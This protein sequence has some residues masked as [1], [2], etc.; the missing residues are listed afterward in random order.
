MQQPTPISTH[1]R[2]ATI[3]I[4]RGFALLGIFLVNIPALSAPALIYDLYSIQPAYE[5][6]DRWVRLIYDLFVQAK[7]YPMFSFLFGFGFYIFLSRAEL[8]TDQPRKLFIRRLVILLT[9]GLLHLVFVWYGDILHTYA[10]IGFLLLF[11]YPL[12]PKT[13]LIWAAS[14]LFLFYALLALPL[15]APPSHYDSLNYIGE[16]VGNNKVEESVR[17]YREAGYFELT[18]YRFQ[19][20]VLPVLEY[21]LFNIPQILAL[22]LLGLYVGKKGII[23]EPG[24][25]R[26]LIR[27]IWGISIII[28]FPLMIWLTSIELGWLDYGVHEESFSYLLMNLSGMFLASFYIFS[29]VLFLEKIRMNRILQS[30]QAAGKMALTNYLAQTSLSVI[31][32]VGLGFYN[33]VSLTFGLLMVLVFF[34][35]QLV[36]SHYWLKYFHFGP[37]EWL[38][39]SLTY[40]Q[41]QPMKRKDPPNKKTTL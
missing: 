9:F 4:I 22:F 34:S 27:K 11:F 16:T 26:M 24:S 15:L 40:K 23:A 35:I 25:H 13:L 3:D 36:Y 28:A 19:N 21:F 1:Q 14:L 17:M 41:R 8:K 2:I 39:R 5:G 31:F 10:L 6:M 12:R 7:F 30:F 20:E 37:F 33:K 38:W 29:A 32:F 18:A